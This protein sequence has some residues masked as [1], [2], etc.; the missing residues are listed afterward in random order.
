M[1]YSLSG[2]FLEDEAPKGSGSL[3]I[4]EEIPVDLTTFIQDKRY[5][6][7]PPLSP[8]QFEAVRHIERIYYDKADA[9]GHFDTY[10]MLAEEEDFGWYWAEPVPMK[11][12]ITLQWGKGCK[13]GNM[14]IYNARTGDW[15]PVSEWK[16][17]LVAGA[18]EEGVIGSYQSSDSWITGRGDSFRVK[19]TNG[20]QDDVYAGHRYLVRGKIDQRGSRESRKYYSS[21]KQLRDISVGDYIAV[22]TSIPS[23]TNP[24]LLPD[25]HVE[26]LGLL[27]GD[28]CLPD[29]SKKRYSVSLTVGTKDSVV[30]DRF[31]SLVQE[32]GG[33][34]RADRADHRINLYAVSPDGHKAGSN[35]VMQMLRGYGLDGFH[36]RTKF[37]PAAVFRTSNEQ[38]ALFLAR[39]IDTD[40]HIYV[41]KGVPEVGYTTASY[42]LAVGVQRLLLRLGCRAQIQNKSVLYDG[43]RRTYFCVRMRDRTN[44]LRF[45]KQIRT[46][47]KEDQRERAIVSCVEGNG[48]FRAGQEDLAWEK[49]VSIESLGEQDYW[50]I[51]VPDVHNYVSN[52]TLNHNS[53]KDHICRM[54]ALRV[55]YLLLCLKSPQQYFGMP[56]QDTITM[57][58]I[59][60]NS[61]QANR[62]FFKPMTK[63]VE[64]SPWFKGKAEIKQGHIEYDKNIEA[65]SGHSDAEGQE[66][67]NLILGVADEIDAFKSKDEMMIRGNQ[68]R[69]A[70]T[71]AESILEM[72]ETSAA[73]RF[74]ETH[75]RVAISFPRYLGSTIQKLTDAGKKS[76]E[77][78]GAKSTHFVSGPLATWEVNPRVSGP[79]AFADQY[80]E[81]PDMAR[82]KFECRPSR[83][84]D[85]YFRNMA[86]F[87]NAIDKDEQPITFEYKLVERK[88]SITGQ[89]VT[90]WVPS[91][92]FASDFLPVQGAVY[93]MHG[94]LAVTG[95]RAGIAMSHIESWVETTEIIQ[96]EEGTDMEVTSNYPII[97][98]DFTIAFESSLRAE[99]FA[100]EIQISW[101]RELCYALIKRGFRIAR[102]T[103]DQFQSKDTMQLLARHGIESERVSMDINDDG[104][105][106]TKDVAYSGR[107]R[108]PYDKLLLEE[109]TALGRGRN[110][111]VDHPPG[112]SKDMADAFGASILGALEVGGEEDPNGAIIDVGEPLFQ[113]GPAM[114]ALAGLDAQY[115][116]A[117]PIGMK[118]T[119]LY[120]G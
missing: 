13:M 94:D 18:T 47:S 50:D 120:G 23:P 10:A 15:T 49:I 24:T 12:L 16:S 51:E 93:A 113:V 110:G 32:L 71:S 11:N 80:E 42:D 4:F 78:K 46:L 84:A 9:K 86:A 34:V 72:I 60:V 109:L 95:D 6:N 53:G 117:T 28:G 59:A 96:D 61:Q 20:L 63:A 102:F 65:V 27:L 7:N 31:T 45:C 48:K 112:G 116:L 56:E 104:W 14:P 69:E 57:L 52:G 43:E 67:G 54:A 3:E 79:E 29:S 118:G 5:L 25:S 82:A 75:K 115:A 87:K 119:D 8:V 74:P 1:A 2:L 88:S 85:S 111:K 103:F 38:I 36:A 70:S 89:M 26:M 39:L 68:F 37:V 92:H 33:L 83:A 22:P 58:N 107:L 81:N 55:A 17:D 21:W 64:T 76:I 114:S 30:T 90:S 40:G 106:A 105:K 41:G 91:F 108:M 99:P 101:A 77:K 100:R 44:V 19:T 35:P 98:N 97:R 62:A 73:T 66:G